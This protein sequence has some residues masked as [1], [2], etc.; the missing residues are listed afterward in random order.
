MVFWKILGADEIPKG[1]QVKQKRP[2]W[3]LMTT[4]FW[5]WASSFS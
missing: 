1:N 3:A 2:L 5:E 4:N